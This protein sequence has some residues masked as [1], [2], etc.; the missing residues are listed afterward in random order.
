MLIE[1]S[2]LPMIV[3][4]QILTAKSDEII[5][6]VDNGQVIKNIHL[7]E[8]KSYANGDFDFDLERMQ[9]A[10][11]ET[12]ENGHAKHTITVPKGL[13]KDKEAFREWVKANAS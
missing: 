10:I 7:L 1:L 9:Q 11:G 4:Q 13:A 3:Q 6:I 5:Q 12:D 8:P 2:H